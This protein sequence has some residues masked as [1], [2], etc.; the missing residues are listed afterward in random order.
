MFGI[1][2]PDVATDDGRALVGVP[3]GAERTDLRLAA[4]LL[5]PAG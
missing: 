3:A 1:E 4:R 5:A 2:L